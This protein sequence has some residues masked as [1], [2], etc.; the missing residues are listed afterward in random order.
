MRVARSSSGCPSFVAAYHGK[1]DRIVH[2]DAANRH[3]VPLIGRGPTK[4]ECHAICAEP[5]LKRPAMYDMG[6]PNDNRIGCVKGGMGHWNPIRRDFPDVSG[7]RAGREREIGHSRIEGVFPD[8]LDPNR[9]NT[10]TEAMPSR[11]LAC[12]AIETQMEGSHG[13]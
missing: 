3:P 1:P 4:A 9:G 5:G 7:R 12:E 2:I 13:V 11:G 6:Y 8:E 10:I